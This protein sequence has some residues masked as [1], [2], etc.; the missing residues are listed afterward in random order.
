MTALRV[1]QKTSHDTITV[2]FSEVVA[3]G[4]FCKQK[5]VSTPHCFGHI[6]SMNDWNSI[7][8]APNDTL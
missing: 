3:R 4:K 8:V 2:L 1:N 5:H 6:S 7:N